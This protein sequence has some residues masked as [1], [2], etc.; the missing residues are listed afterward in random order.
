MVLRECDLYHHWGPF[1]TKSKKLAQLD[2]LD[3]VAWFSVGVPMLGLTR[4]ACYRAVGCDCMNENGSVML[5]AVGLNDEGE[6]CD[7]K[8]GLHF[9]K[10]D[11]Q[12]KQNANATTHS[13]SKYLVDTS[14]SSFLSRDEIILTLEKPPVPQG[15]GSGS[16]T[17]R[18]F[19]A[20]INIL[21]PTSARTKM[22]VNID[23]NVPMM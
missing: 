16:M 10:D 15:L 17:I 19:S 18:N 9:E 11:G 22:V 6:E 4:D 8:D 13:E 1:V 2:K 7:A 23:P 21:S 12:S 20:S 5:V 3:V 14:T